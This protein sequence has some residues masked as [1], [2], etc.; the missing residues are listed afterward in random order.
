LKILNKKEG[1]LLTEI[2]AAF[3]LFVLFALFIS[4]YQI[5]CLKLNE[6]SSK[7]SQALNISLEYLGKSLANGKK[8]NDLDPAFRLLIRD[9]PYQTDLQNIH[10]RLNAFLGQ[11]CKFNVKDFRLIEVLVVFNLLDG[12]KGEVKIKKGF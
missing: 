3:S 8:E 6:H 7:R 10:F 2:L 5:L 4:K 11:E 1:F 12:K 9:L